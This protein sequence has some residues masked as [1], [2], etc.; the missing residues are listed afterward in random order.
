MSTTI[1][2][3][4]VQTFDEIRRVC[5]MCHGLDLSGSELFSDKK[6]FELSEATRNVLRNTLSGSLLQLAIA[7]RVNIYQ[8]SFDGLEKRKLPWWASWYYMDENQI[9]EADLKT[10]CDKIIHADRVDKSVLPSLLSE[11]GKM[12]MHFVGSHH[13]RKWIMDFPVDE[14]VEYLLCLLDEVEN[15]NA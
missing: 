12:C 11:N 1:I 15:D 2:E 5:L 13:G 10:I 8:S 7:V 14:F 6:E 9:K 4:H 3:R